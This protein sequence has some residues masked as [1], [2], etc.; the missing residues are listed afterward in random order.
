M[1]GREAVLRRLAYT[2]VGSRVWL[3]ARPKH[4]SMGVELAEHEVAYAV[5]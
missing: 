3:G 1:I 5:G 4:A 2:P